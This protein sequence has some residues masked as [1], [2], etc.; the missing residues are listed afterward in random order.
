MRAACLAALLALAG[1]A[2]APA[3]PPPPP[4]ALV[5]AFADEF[6]SG[7]IVPRDCV[8]ARWWPRPAPYPWL[9]LHYGER[10]WITGEA[11]GV[12]PALRLALIGGEGGVQIDSVLSWRH[13]RGGTD[14]DRVRLW[15][16]PVSAAEAAALG[17]RLSWWIEASGSPGALGP[18]SRWWPSARPW[19]LFTNCHDFTADLLAAAGIAVERP[20][21]MQ[22][23]P[24]RAALDRAWAA[25]HG[26]PQPPPV[27]RPAAPA[28]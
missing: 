15:V 28:H 16:F 3:R 21:I 20:P 13:R 7:V 11:H 27:A 12:W 22:A 6:H 4:E 14:P 5:V 1:C 18:T 24:L 9:V 10:R 2:A 26:A 17:E 25:R 19:T 23:A 8:P